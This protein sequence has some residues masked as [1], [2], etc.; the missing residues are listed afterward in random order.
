MAKLLVPKSE[1]VGE[2]NGDVVRQN[3]KMQLKAQTL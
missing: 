1:G 3:T 2:K